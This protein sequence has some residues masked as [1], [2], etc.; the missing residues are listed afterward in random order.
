MQGLAARTVFET[1]PLANVVC[2]SM[3]NPR[4][5]GA[6]VPRDA[7]RGGAARL[8]LDYEANGIGRWTERASARTRSAQI[9]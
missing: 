1:G 4:R 5:A 6:R 3:G 2:A 9:A 7:C 8:S